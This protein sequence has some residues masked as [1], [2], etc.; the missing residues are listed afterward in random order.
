M[1]DSSDH[2]KKR[3]QMFIIV[4][5]SVILAALLVS[6]WL[7]IVLPWDALERVASI[8]SICLGLFYLVV[9]SLV[10]LHKLRQGHFGIGPS[11][12]GAFLLGGGW[13]MYGVYFLL[14][15]PPFL[16]LCGVTLMLGGFLAVR[17]ARR[18]SRT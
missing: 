14:D 13:L 4:G 15:G 7:H 11:V 12:P 18:R 3:I 10:A 17:A 16:G 9:A 2:E 8:G 6:N 5:L 1:V